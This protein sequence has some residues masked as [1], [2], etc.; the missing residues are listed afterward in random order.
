MNSKKFKDAL[1]EHREVTDIKDLIT[2]SAELY[3]N[4]TAFLVKK[5]HSEPF[6]PITYGR[7]KKDIDY[8]GTSLVNMGLKGKRIAVIG[9][10]SYEW[11]VSY[12]AVTM[13][14]GVVVP[15]DRELKAPEIANLLNRSKAEA[16][17]YSRKMEKTIKEVLPLT[18]TI[19]YHINM[20]TDK[21]REGELAM[22]DLID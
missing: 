9:E 20:N 16:L 10:N 17:I 15:I 6:Q 2:S 3:E 21:P 18:E 14:T 8:L 19:Q 12:F 13:G 11:V 7:F 22:M 4:N 1:Y 5:K